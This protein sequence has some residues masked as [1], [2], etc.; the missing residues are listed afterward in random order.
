MAGATRL[1]SEFKTLLKRK[2]FENFIAA[3]EE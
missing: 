2:N 3:P 1:Q